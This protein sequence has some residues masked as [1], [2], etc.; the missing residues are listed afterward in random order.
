M[1]ITSVLSM[2]GILHAAASRDLSRLNAGVH[3][4]FMGDGVTAINDIVTINY[5]VRLQVQDAIPLIS[6][7]ASICANVTL[8]TAIHYC[9]TLQRLISNLELEVNEHANSINKLRSES[10]NM[11]SLFTANSQD[12]RAVFL[13]PVGNFLGENTI[14]NS[15]THIDYSYV[16]YN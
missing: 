11:M 15:H 6:N 7:N 2:L 9:A 13:Q 12:K 4:E 3:L 5:N 1:M 8:P 10:L 16:I 14:Y